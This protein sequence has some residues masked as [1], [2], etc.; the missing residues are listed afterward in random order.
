MEKEVDSRMK[1]VDG[2]KPFVGQK[3][4]MA[5]K[6]APPRKVDKVMPPSKAKWES[7]AN[8]F[9]LSQKIQNTDSLGNV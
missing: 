8:L 4:K 9:T 2:N 7:C 1:E 6:S 3:G 5:K